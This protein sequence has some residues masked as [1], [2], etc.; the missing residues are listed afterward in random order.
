M[1]DGFGF[2][3]GAGRFRFRAESRIVSRLIEGANR[4]GTVLDLGCGIGYWTEFFARHFA[5]AVAVEASAPLYQALQKRCE[6]YANVK[7]VH[8]D[9]TSFE[10]KERYALVFLGGMLMYLNDNDGISLL[11]RLTPFLETGG[12]ILCRETT[13]RQ[14]IVT[15]QG[16]YQAVYRSVENYTEIFEQSGL[17]VA[18]IQKNVPY[19]LLQMGCELVRKWQSLVPKRLQ[20][21]AAVGRLVYWGLRLGHPWIARVPEALGMAYP[22]LTNHFFVLRAAP[23]RVP[24]DPTHSAGPE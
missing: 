7:T 23:A 10:P 3:A 9:V 13:V 5:R 19:V 4:R 18:H 6:P 2:P 16:E 8:G 14:G 11:R 20:A 21:T 17:A 22:E 1:L 12:L 15:R 24:G